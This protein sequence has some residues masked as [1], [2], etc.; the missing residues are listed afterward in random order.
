MDFHFFFPFSNYSKFADRLA[1][2]SFIFETHDRTITFGE[3][4]SVGYISPKTS[5]ISDF[6]NS[7][8]HTLS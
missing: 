1:L 8:L 5:V 2:Y 4:F 7:C 6:S 3:D